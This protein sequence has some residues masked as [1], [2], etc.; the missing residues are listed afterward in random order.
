MKK[1]QHI[2][3]ATDIFFIVPSYPT[4]Q[5]LAI[6]SQIGFPRCPIVASFQYS[7]LRS[8]YDGRIP[9]FIS[10]KNSSKKNED[11]YS[12]TD[13]TPLKKYFYPCINSVVLT[14][15]HAGSFPGA[16]GHMDP[17]LIYVRCV[18]TDFVRG[19]NTINIHVYLI[20]STFTFLFL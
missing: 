14:H 17:M 2:V 15:G 5:Y 1:R 18:L 4:R 20:L 3:A 12:F 7:I 6:G 16:H 8:M 13:K 11:S 10:S 9:T 19:T